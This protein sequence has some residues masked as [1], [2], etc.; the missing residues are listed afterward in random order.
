MGPFAGDYAE[1][2]DDGDDDHRRPSF[3]PSVRLGRSA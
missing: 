3:R 2:D 1:I